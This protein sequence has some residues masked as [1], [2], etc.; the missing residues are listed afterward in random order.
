MA[1]M[2]TKL[3]TKAQWRMIAA[4]ERRGYDL[5]HT[6]D[7]GNPVLVLRSERIWVEIMPKGNYQ[8]A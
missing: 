7:R 6:S 1:H 5:S 2:R 4:L 3:L 8:P